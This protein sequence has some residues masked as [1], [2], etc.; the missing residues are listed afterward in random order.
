VRS[1]LNAARR[2]VNQAA[3][4]WPVARVNTTLTCIGELD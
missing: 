4:G 2:A 3:S 1:S